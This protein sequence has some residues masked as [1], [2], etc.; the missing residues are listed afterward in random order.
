MTRDEYGER[1]YVIFNNMHQRCG[2]P[3]NQ[4]YSRY[5]G[6]G[7]TVDPTWY[8]FDE[9]KRW[10]EANG[11]SRY[12]TLDRLKNDQG[13]TPSN[14]RWATYTTQA[15]NKGKRTGGSS[16]FIGVSWYPRNKKW[17]ASVFVDGKNQYLGLFPTEEDAA[18]ARD[19]YIVV[20]ALADFNLNFP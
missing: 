5:G 2:N 6:K 13:Y 18:R 12:L 15:R 11:Y 16:Q 19:N 3:N 14:C 4:A 7:I 1:L 8:D 9:F 17:S 20:N 10:A